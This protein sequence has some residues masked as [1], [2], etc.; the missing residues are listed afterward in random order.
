MAG[1]YKTVGR[2][3][4]LHVLKEHPD[5]P[6][7]AEELSLELNRES[8]SGGKSSIYR[9][10]SELCDEGTVRKYRGENQTAYV[11]QYI[12]TRDCSHHFHLKCI[13]CGRVVHLECAV[14]EDLL[15]HI[16]QSHGF[17]IDRGK[18]MLYGTCEEC[19]ESGGDADSTKKL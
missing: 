4:L 6:L 19:R 13:N 3:R 5:R 17:T 9:H 14:S 10:L 1:T 8:P 15:T 18:S 16:R 12:G 7:T 11:Y 2:E